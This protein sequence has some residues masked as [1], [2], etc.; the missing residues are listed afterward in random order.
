MTTALYLRVSTS[1]QGHSTQ[2]RELNRYC[3]TRN[4]KQPEEYLD[5][6]S[7]SRSDRGGL[8]RLMEAVRAGRVKRVVVYKLDRLGRSLAHLA[9]ILSEFESRGVDLI[10]TSQGIDTSG[11]NPAGRLQLNVLM[12][13]AEFER[14]LIRERVNAGLAAARAR[15]VQLG[16]PRRINRGRVE[17]LR[18]EGMGIREI[19]RTLKASPSTISAILQDATA[20]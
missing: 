5:K 8:E 1:A 9:M 14:S 12:A 7:G 13:V 10:C 6:A 11:D 18:G 3:R 17:R 16:R 20:S 15:G 19:A 4:W 2:R